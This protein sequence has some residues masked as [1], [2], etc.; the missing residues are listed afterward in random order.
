MASTPQVVANVSNESVEC[1]PKINAENTDSS[2]NKDQID[3][4]TFREVCQQAFSHSFID[5]TS[6]LPVEKLFTEAIGP[7]QTVSH[8]IQGN[9]LF[10]N[11]PLDNSLS[12]S[13][14][15]IFLINSTFLN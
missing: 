9:G 2:T 15:P 3:S 6:L 11:L 7:I 10:I 5:L 8:H 1:C 12:Y 4:C 14:P 13:T